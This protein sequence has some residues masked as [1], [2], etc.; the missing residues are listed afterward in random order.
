MDGP[1]GRWSQ[2]KQKDVY[3]DKNTGVGFMIVTE[4][5]EAHSRCTFL[6]ETLITSMPDVAL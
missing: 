4:S 1:A 3:E 6:L 5:T 2:Q